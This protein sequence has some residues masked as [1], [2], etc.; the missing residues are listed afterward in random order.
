MVKS[1]PVNAGDAG[2]MGSIP[3]LGRS[4]GVG[5]WSRKWQLT[6]VFL[7]GEAHGQDEPGGLQSSGS[8]T[9]GHS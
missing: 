1:P 8:Q 6:P 2:S 4:P 3:G 7:R 9:A 5:P